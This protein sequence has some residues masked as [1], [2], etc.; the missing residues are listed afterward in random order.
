MKGVYQIRNIIT[1]KVYV[2]SSID[3]ETRWRKHKE[4]LNKKNHHSPYLQNA[5]EKYGENSFVFEII[6]EIYN[7]KELI[8]LE[9]KW[10]DEKVAYSRECGYNARRQADSPLGT[11]W[12]KERKKNLSDKISGVNHP[13]YGK[14]LTQEHRS[15]ISSSNKGKTAWN[16]G[17]KTSQETIKHLQAARKSQISLPHS[18]KTK[19]KISLALLGHEVKRETR[20]KLSEANFGKTLSEETKKKI[21][22]SSIKN[23]PPKLSY[24]QVQEI[25]KLKGTLSQTKIAELYGVSQSTI[26]KIFLEAYSG[27]IS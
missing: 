26:S 11:V 25:K 27:R 15:K 8:I 21:K 17:K 2:G 13:F 16:K 14:H 3:I 1:D 12:T 18:Q 7:E 24:E 22:E 4:L 20:K 5:W 6:E 19:E 23:S 10:I 9:Q